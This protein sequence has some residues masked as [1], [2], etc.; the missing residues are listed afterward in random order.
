MYSTIQMLKEIEKST[1]ENAYLLTGEE[2]YLK[3]QGLKK[4][5]LKALSEETTVFDKIVLH[6][7]SATS[8]EIMSA[9]FSVPMIAS[10]RVVIIRE[11]HRLDANGKNQLLKYL[12][13]PV[14]STCLIL[15]VSK[16]DLG[17]GFPSK[18][19]KMVRV[20]DFKKLTRGESSRVLLLSLKKYGMTITD[21]ARELLLESVGSDT[22]RLV[23]ELDKLA[24][25][26]SGS[27][28]INR[29]DVEELVDLGRLQN[30]F[31]LQDSVGRKEVRKAL[32][33]IEQLLLWNEKPS[34]ILASLGSFY[35]TL[36]RL[37]G[38]PKHTHPDKT[39]SKLR[40]SSFYIKQC[41]RHLS[42]FSE[43]ELISALEL[44]SQKELEMKE[45]SACI[46]PLLTTYINQLCSL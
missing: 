34:R 15:L 7:D 8:E 27:K 30:I 36:L 31:R 5:L 45:G 2:E 43:K 24:S 16:V 41:A 14:K 1:L 3:E 25:Y 17:K 29:N 33:I 39:A 20:Y 4:I 11:A 38:E 26:K 42:S 22:F 12:S 19:S 40:L 37:K 23:S 21:E 9:L 32:A 18:V 35:L 10:K 28:S 44:T 6:G 13:D 46:R